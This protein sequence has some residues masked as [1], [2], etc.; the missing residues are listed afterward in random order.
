MAFAASGSATEPSVSYCLISWWGLTTFR[1]TFRE[2]AD[3]GLADISALRFWLLGGAADDLSP[4]DLFFAMTL[5]LGSRLHSPFSPIKE[6]P[7]SVRQSHRLAL[8]A[9]PFDIKW[10]AGHKLLSIDKQKEI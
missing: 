3:S 10:I 7:K 2:F 1:G 8:S 6:L 5:L 4:D 9:D